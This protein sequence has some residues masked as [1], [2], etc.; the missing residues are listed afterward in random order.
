VAPVQAREEAPIRTTRQ[1]VEALGMAWPQ[2]YSKPP[3]QKTL[4]F[5]ARGR[6]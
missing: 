2:A 5:Q 3:I 4:V 1:L 6:P